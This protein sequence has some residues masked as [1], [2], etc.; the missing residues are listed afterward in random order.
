MA[1]MVLDT[2][3]LTGKAVEVSPCRIGINNMLVLKFLRYPISLERRMSL[4]MGL[5][6]QPGVSVMCLGVVSC[7]MKCLGQIT[8]IVKQHYLN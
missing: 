3:G 5:I 1:H 7:H 6:G 4:L 8:F 2:S